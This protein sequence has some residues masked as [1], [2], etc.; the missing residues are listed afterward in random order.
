MADSDAT[1]IKGTIALTGGRAFYF[2][3]LL[4][5]TKAGHCHDSQHAGCWGRAESSQYT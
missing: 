4:S 2:V 3:C 5:L 1:R